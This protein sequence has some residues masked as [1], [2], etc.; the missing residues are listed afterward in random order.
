MKFRNIVPMVAVVIGMAAIFGTGEAASVAATTKVYPIVDVSTGFLL[1]GTAQGQWLS[2]EVMSDTV[3]GGQR[4][5]VYNLKGFL[6]RGTGTGAEEAGAPC[7]DTRIVEMKPSFEGV[8]A[9]G[10]GGSWAAMPRVPKRVP[11]GSAFYAK[12]VADMLKANG[13]DDPDVNI[14]Q[15]LRID[16]EGD[17]TSEVLV[18]ASHFAGS[19]NN[20]PLPS[21]EP[22]DYSIVFMRKV[23]RG[24]VKTVVL[25]KE[26]ITEKIE[27]GAPS[28]YSVEGVLDLN[29]DRVMEVVL[30]GR[31][32]EGG[33]SSVYEVKGTDVE[34]VLSAGCGA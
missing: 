8:G 19:E 16:L 28:K 17:G 4:Y 34:E 20:E 23:V 32:Y 1:G 10:S 2:T 31:Y 7:E 22:G 24:E 30:N 27:F 14:E 21:A 25:A 18:S 6:G 3:A 12:A 5:R 26:I 29:G 13:I 11:V 9:I 15:I 33:W